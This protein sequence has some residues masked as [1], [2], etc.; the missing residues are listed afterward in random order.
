[1]EEKKTTVIPLVTASEQ[2]KAQTENLVQLILNPNCSLSSSILCVVDFLKNDWVKKKHLF[3]S[4]KGGVNVFFFSL[5]KRSLE[6]DGI[7]GET[8]V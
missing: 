2:G 4:R 5:I 8:P 7:E 3:S 1:V 6:R